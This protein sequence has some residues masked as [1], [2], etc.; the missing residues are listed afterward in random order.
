MRTWKKGVA[1]LISATIWLGFGRKR[2]VLIASALMIALVWGPNFLGAIEYS[3]TGK[4]ENVFMIA[5]TIGVTPI[6]NT[7]YGFLYDSLG[8]SLAIRH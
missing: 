8:Y 3:L 5:E 1:A 6:L 7:V 2:S 4:N